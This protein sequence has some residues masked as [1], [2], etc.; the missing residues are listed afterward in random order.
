M[1]GAPRRVK[2]VERVHQ[3]AVTAGAKSCPWTYALVQFESMNWKRILAYVTGSVDE[4]LLAQNEYL[5]TENRILRNQ[6]QGR[7]R[8]TDPERISLASAAKLLG[9]KG[10]EEVA[11]I[12]RPE[13]ILGWHRRL[14]AKKF[15]GSKNRSAGKDGDSTRDMIEELILQLARENRTWGYRRIAGALINLGHEV[16]HQTVANVLKQNDVAPAPER[17]RTMSWGEFIRS[18]LEVL[19]AVDFFTVE[20]WTAG[21]L[22]TFYVLSCMRV[23]SR[24]VCIAGITTSPDQRWMEQMARNLTFADT[25]FLNGCRYL[26]HDRDAKFCTA[27]TGILEAVKIKAVKLPARSPNLNAYLERWHRSV[28]EECLSKM[29][30]F[31]EAS[32]KQVLSNYVL[33][34]HGERNHQGKG[35]V[36]LF[37]RPEDRI[38][39]S[40]CDIHTRQRL[41]GLLKFYYREAA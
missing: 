4:E 12:V 27:F 13:T 8:L 39:E 20:V 28:K 33:H 30:L 35:N 36:I 15:D 11:Q 14:I 1:G 5:V 2:P 21:G 40:S 19:A 6:I 18:H 25:G 3:Q 41:G 29:I 7:I 38:G 26:L 31:G 16:S 24:Q 10:L 37:P 34:I 22:M 23:A 9:R 32:L 17:G